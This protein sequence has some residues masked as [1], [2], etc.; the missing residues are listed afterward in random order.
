MG[1]SDSKALNLFEIS[2]F[3]RK[4]SD[5]LKIEF[6]YKKLVLEFLDGN[7]S[8]TVAI[9]LSIPVEVAKKFKNVLFEML[10]DF[11]D[12]RKYVSFIEMYDIT[13]E[14]FL[15]LTNS[16]KYVYYFILLK[17]GKGEAPFIDL[18]KNT[19][20]INEVKRQEYLRLHN[21]NETNEIN[22]SN[23]EQPKEIETKDNQPKRVLR[24]TIPQIENKSKPYSTTMPE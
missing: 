20:F 4:L 5:F 6:R 10:P 22:E 7:S 8:E 17:H 16:S 24:Q 1:Q 11:D 21:S 9:N 23:D 18:V 15:W 2:F 13:L 19:P 3:P 12:V 14:N